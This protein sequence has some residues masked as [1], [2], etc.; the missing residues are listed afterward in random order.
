[1]YKKGSDLPKEIIPLKNTDKKDHE[2]WT[3]GRDLLDFPSPFAMLIVGP[4]NCGKTTLIKNLLIRKL[5]D[6]AYLCHYDPEGTTEYKL[7][8]IQVL[9]A[10]YIPSNSEIPIEGR[11]CIIF[12]DIPYD[13]LSKEDKLK[14]QGLIKYSVS[15]RNV[16]FIFS[17]HDFTTG[18]PPQLRRLFNVF[19]IYKIPDVSSLK[20]IG[21]RCGLKSEDF[22]DL[23]ENF[24][25]EQHDSICIDLTKDSPA[26]LR[27]NIYQKIKMQR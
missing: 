13:T 4:R 15:H 9:P 14:M 21:T 11:K 5:Y 3:A 8:D 17:T 18:T 23:F 22:Q 12:E 24:I 10:G 2:R 6:D 1:M 19:I 16:D 25:K 26:P 20:T 7:T 27:L